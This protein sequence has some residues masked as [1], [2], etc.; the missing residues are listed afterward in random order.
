MNL[1]K[2]DIIGYGVCTDS[3]SQII[4]WVMCG[5]EENYRQCKYFACLNPHAAVIAED[6]QVF[7]MSLDHANFLTADGI[8]VVYA[9]RISSGDLNRRVTGMDVFL[10]I[11]ETMD[12]TTGGSCFFL[13]STEQ[14]LKKIRRRM[15][16]KFP[17]VIVAGTYSPPYKS[18]FSADDNEKMIQAIN[19]A[20]PD[21]LWVGLTAPKQ[22]KWIFEHRHRLDVNFAGPIGAAF[23]FFVGNIKRVGPFWQNMGFEWLPRLIQEPR[24]LW[25][26]SLVSAPK[27]FWRVIRYRQQQI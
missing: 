23:D 26:R 12:K 1:N 16:I 13:G 4:S 19:E 8:G 18:E 21:V 6:D 14:T 5:I 20:S 17:N 15:A 2:E 3:I 10:G 24:R 25:R 7:Q 27:F 11:T 9:S 22:E